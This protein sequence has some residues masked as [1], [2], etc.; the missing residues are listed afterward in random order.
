MR[1]ACVYRLTRMFAPLATACVVALATLTLPSLGGR[2]APLTSLSGVSVAASAGWVRDVLDPARGDEALTLTA[3]LALPP[4]TAAALRGTLVAVSDPTSAEYGSYLSRSE[5]RAL[6]APDAEAVAAVTAWFERAG[7]AEVLAL[8]TGDLL[9]AE[10]TVTQVERALGVEV[11]AF[12]HESRRHRILRTLDTVALPSALEGAVA[13]LVGVSEWPLLPELLSSSSAAG[14]VVAAAEAVDA[15]H[16]SAVGGTALAGG[17]PPPPWGPGKVEVT[18]AKLAELY[19]LPVD[20]DDNPQPVGSDTSASQAAAEFEGQAFNPES[21]ASFQKVFG[22]ADQPVRR[23]TPGSGSA[24][25]NRTEMLCVEADLDVQYIEAAAPGVPTD[26]WLDKKDKF[27]LLGWLAFASSDENAPLVWSVSYGEGINGGL[28]GKIEAS[29]AV[30]VDQ[31]I[32]KL[33][34]LGVSVLMASGDNGVWNRRWYDVFKFHP[35][36]PACLPHATAVGGTE[37]RANATNTTVGA[38]D[39]VAWVSSGGGFTPR[40]Y[41]TLEADA[42][43]QKEAVEG[44]LNSSSVTFPDAKYWDRT[45]RGLP[46]LAAAS[47]N[48]QVYEMSTHK[49]PGDRVMVGGTSASTP[50]VAAIVSR[51]NDAR[52]RKGLAPMGYLNPFLYVGRRLSDICWSRTHFLFLELFLTLSLPLFR[53]RYANPGAFRDITEGKND[54]AN[55]RGG[56]EASKGWD[57]ATGLGVVDFPKLLKAALQA[58][59]A[60]AAARRNQQL[61]RQKIKLGGT[62]VDTDG[63]LGRHPSSSL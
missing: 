45:G 18:P 1:A 56:F 9:R 20:G 4:E 11:V 51:L 35:F 42:P 40:E 17:G 30:R 27:D 61:L 31:E 34:V 36:F 54:N 57:P 22:L 2:P 37:F 41:F 19:N 15:S 32:Q 46:D 13:A 26:M 59:E 50:V 24:A 48:Y 6:V 23:S 39:D 7:A 14:A 53:C 62:V 43:W 63:D 5:L 52:L 28:G 58:G 12:R 16:P 55:K 8:G 25:A 21:L 29:Y 47:Y 49:P 3:A 44:Y 60:A 10:V 38:I 33:G